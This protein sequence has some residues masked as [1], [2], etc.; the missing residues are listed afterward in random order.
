MLLILTLLVQVALHRFL[1]SLRV[2]VCGVVKV[3]KTHQILL[4]AL[5]RVDHIA[6]SLVVLVAVVMATMITVVAPE[7]PQGVQVM[8]VAET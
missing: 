3:K 7:A 2:A 4:E 1:A 8:V 5:A 6:I